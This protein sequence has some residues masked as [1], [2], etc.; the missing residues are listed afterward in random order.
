MI[1]SSA[2][3]GI[4]QDLAEPKAKAKLYRMG[5][6]AWRNAVLARW[7]WSGADAGDVAWRWLA[8][9]GDRWPPPEFPV[10]GGDLLAFGMDAGPQVGAILRELEVEWVAGGFEAGRDALLARACV[11]LAT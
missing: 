6:P 9:L 7:A 4:R 5:A 3:L 11:P 1:A 8:T 2:S 10:R